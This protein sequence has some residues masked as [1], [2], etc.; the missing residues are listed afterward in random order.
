KRYIKFRNSL[1]DDAWLAARYAEVKRRLAARFSF[2]RDAYTNGKTGFIEA[3]LA[4]PPRGC[5]SVPMARPP[6]AFTSQQP[7]HSAP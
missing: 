3:V 7:A 1:R 2:D 5:Q 4:M 6:F